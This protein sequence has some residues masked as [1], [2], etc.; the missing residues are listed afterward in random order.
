VFDE[1]GGAAAVAR[2]DDGAGREHPLDGHVAVVFIKGQVA[3]GERVGVQLDDL[4]LRDEAAQLD[5][6]ADAVAAN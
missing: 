2:D 4:L 1:L 6:V 3:D 5:A